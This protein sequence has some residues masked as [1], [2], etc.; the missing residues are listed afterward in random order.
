MV[1]VYILGINVSHDISCAILKNG[2][3]ICAIAEERI[4]RIKRFT[5]G[6]DSQGMTNKHLPHRAIKYC[7]DSAGTT[8]KDVQLIVVSTC[9]VVNYK[10]YRIRSITK[11]EI[12]EQFPSDVDPNKVYVIGH[13]IGHA[14]SAYLSSGFNDSAILVVDGGGSLVEKVD[15]LTATTGYFEE[16]VSLYHG[17]GSHIEL[18]KQ[19]FDGCPSEGFLANP[20][21]SSLG[22]FYQSA[23]IFVGFKGGDEGKTMGLAQYGTDRYYKNF[24]DA[25]HLNNGFLRVRNEFQFNKWR[26]KISQYYGGEFGSPLEY[27]QSL[28]QVDKDIAAAVQYALEEAMVRLA[29]EAHEITKSENICLAGGV[30]LN[31]VANKKILDQTPFK[32]IFIQP[33]SGDD[34][35]A[36]GNALL[37][38]VSILGRPKRWYMRTASTGRPYSD[39]EIRDVIGKYHKWLDIIKEGDIPKAVSTLI[40]QKNIVGWFQGGSEFGPR[41]LGHRSILCDA[42][43]PEMKDILNKKVKHRESFRPFAPSILEEFNQEY[44]DLHCPSPF[45]LFIARVKKPHLVPAITHVDC[46]ARVQTVNREDN[47]IYY[48]LI[49]EY[50]KL[51]GVPLI[52]NTSFNIDGEPIVETPE[53]TIKCFLSTRMDYLVLG[54][55]LL[56]KKYFRSLIFQIWPR[57]IRRILKRQMK[58]SYTRLPLP[59]FLKNFLRKN[60]LRQKPFYIKVPG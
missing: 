29:Q 10:N 52:L 2:E 58:V 14:A 34:G 9:V 38:W 5:G 15:P 18:K 43:F 12:L 48:D 16:R 22:D 28:R 20:K 1:D 17:M 31:S 53:D 26:K 30:A 41:A 24:L 55:M 39:Q 4:N 11:E 33:A 45:M 60:L 46:S 42:R 8:L 36:L 35:C 3:L 25:I 50:Y 54:N 19:Y 6:I 37:G 40:A 56:K 7:L 59:A 47:G 57:E 27:G 23:T 49:Y 32:N 13:H 21:H 44:F 51:T